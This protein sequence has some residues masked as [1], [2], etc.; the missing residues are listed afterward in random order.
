MLT[1]PMEGR[2][3]LP[4]YEYLCRCIRSDILGGVLPAGT[5]L[6][7][8]RALAE[9]LH[10]SV[11]T[12]ESAY[13]QL[14]AEGYLQAQPKRGF[15][16]AAVEQIPPVLRE[17]APLPEQSPPRW[18]LDLSRNQVDTTRFPVSTWARLTRQ[19]LSE[20]PE[21]LLS[22][23][24]HQGLAAL[25]QAIAADLR[26]FRGMAVSPEQ[27]VIGAGAEYLYLLLAQLLGRDTVFALEDPGY[28]KIRQVYGACGAACVPIPLD[29]QGIGLEALAASGASALHISPN[30]QYPTGLVTPIARRQALLRWAD[31]TGGTVIEDDYDSEFRF[32]GRPIPT[33]QSIDS[34]GR[35]IYLNTFSQTISPSMRLGFLVL[36]PRLL[37]QYRRELGFYACTVP[38]LE[39]HV[40]ARFISG[41]HYERHLSRM[42][43]EYRDRRAQVV[44]A[45]RSS[46][47][48]P[49]VTF[50]EER[51]GLHFLLRLDT[52][53]PDRELGQLAARDGVRLSFLTEYAAMPDPGFAHTLVINY[54]GLS[55]RRLPEAV[56][57][58]SEVLLPLL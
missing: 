26:D 1:Y 45:F 39:Q 29:G 47:L 6:P 9:H 44:E 4:L 13:S 25:R 21:A 38:A 43:K 8:K 48:A 28:P 34:R 16:V 50:S 33:L 7:S 52:R 23:V 36:P 22:P 56:R 27:I 18:R 41:G 42:R 2:G 37:E 53:R 15:F 24:P 58:L 20:E 46:A 49:R 14:E 31:D 32:T 5:R 30:H 11:I 40:L 51:A 3:S 57:L 17:T 54:A 12:V 10:V 55:P 19:V 35:V